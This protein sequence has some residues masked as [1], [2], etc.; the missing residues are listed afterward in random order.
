V[1]RKVEKA[2][3]GLRPLR[4][5][6]PVGLA[7]LV[8]V[9]GVESFT[10]RTSAAHQQTQAPAPSSSS[11]SSSAASAASSSG[12]AQN[13]AP[14]NPAEPGSPPSNGQ[15]N[16][17][18]QVVNVPVTVLDKRGIPVI[19]LTQKDFQVFE[20]GQLQT[21]RYFLQGNRPP[22]RIG[23]VLDTSNSARR[24]IEFERDAAGEFVFKILTGRN[25]PNQIFLEIFDAASS[26]L[27]DFTNDPEIL[28]EKIS[29]LKAGGGKA[30][31]DA[32]YFACRERMLKAGAPADTRRVLV[33]VSDGIDVQSHHSLDEALSMAHLAETAI[34]PIANAAYGFSNDGDKI[35]EEMAAATGGR[36]FFPLK[37]TPGGDMLTGYL[38]HGN[39]GDT[40]QNKGLGAETGIYSAER[41]MHLADSLDAIGN[42]LNEQYSLGYTPTHDILDGTY[43]NIRV[44]V[45]R[46]NV[47]LRSKPG[48]FASP[49]VLQPTVPPK[50]SGQ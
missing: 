10:A 43:R 31:Y 4:K 3:R 28:N 37:E 48:Y 47:S 6:W 15:I 12:A 23:L 35:L 27:Q 1:F 39:V 32:I 2:R 29:N 46:Q 26:I 5:A 42:E 11:A 17:R 14:A 7:G 50:A 19:D 8:L 36:A 34:Y 40:S 44:Q 33:L 21:I 20:D 16:V 45:R 24:Q 9:L 13:P 30:L 18:V 22:L 49:E 41:L 38:S 25:S